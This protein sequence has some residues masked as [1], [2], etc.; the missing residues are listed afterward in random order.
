MLSNQQLDH[1]YRRGHIILRECFSRETAQQMTD[2]AFVRLGYDPHDASTW[3]E[4]RVHMPMHHRYEVRDFAPRAYDAMCQL[5]GGIERIEEPYWSD[6]FIGNFGIGADRPWEAP[7]A[8]VTGWH[9]DG[10]FFRHFLDSPEQALLVIVVW[11]DIEP[12]GGGTF[13]ACDSVP[14]LA[15]F[16]A[17]RPEGVL[18]GEF[19]FQELIQ[20]CRDFEEVT[21]CAGDVVLL[22]PFVLHTVSQ[23]HRGTARMITNPPVHLKEPMNFHR[24]DG[25]YSPVEQSILHA[26]NV[27]HLDFNPQNPRERIVP[28]RVKRQQ[29][30][31]EEELARLALKA[32]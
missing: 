17:E 19:G 25:N 14:V 2:Q 16:L 27:D 5:V 18:P 21:G 13:L 7:S 4:K 22:H 12:R 29:K 23:N 10:D 8:N 32:S 9:K 1:F 31:K 6:G 15:R 11:T 24:A 28:E 30:M 20:E 3:T 26:L